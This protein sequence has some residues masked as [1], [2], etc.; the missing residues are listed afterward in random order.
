MGKAKIAVP[1]PE[2]GG[3]AR[4]RFSMKAIERL[5]VEATASG[6]PRWFADAID[7]C[8]KMR[9]GRI[10]YYAEATLRGATASDLFATLPLGEIA[11]RLL[12]AL[13]RAQY[14]RPLAELEA[15]NA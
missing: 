3:K 14:G 11:T 5:C 15:S 1:I 13:C 8:H 2:L 7:A 9:A 6:N 10:R 12:D 4:L